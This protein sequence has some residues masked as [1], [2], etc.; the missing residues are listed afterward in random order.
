MTGQIE[1]RVGGMYHQDMHTSEM[2][3]IIGAGHCEKLEDGTYR[4]WGRSIGYCIDAK[5]EDAKMLKE[6]LS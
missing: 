4:V 3:E 5:I 6:L 1:A 2:G